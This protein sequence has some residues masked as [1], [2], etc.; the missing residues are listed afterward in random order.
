MQHSFDNTETVEGLLIFSILI[1]NER[2]PIGGL[3]I[4]LLLSKRLGTTGIWCTANAGML[5]LDDMAYSA[6]A[7]PR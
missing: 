6:L 4:S 1:H 7:S 2:L 3:A 5:E